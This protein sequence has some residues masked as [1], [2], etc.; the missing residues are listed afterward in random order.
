MKSIYFFALIS[1]C[2]FSCKKEYTC[3]CEYY[4]ST[5]DPA[6][7]F[8]SEFTLVTETTIEDTQKNAEEECE[9][10]NKN[11]DDG[12]GNVDRVSCTLK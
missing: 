12:N 11:E 6:S 9:G 1:L 2:T 8:S 4:E 10:N 3:A 7:G 5:N